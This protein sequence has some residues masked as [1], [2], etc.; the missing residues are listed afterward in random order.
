MLVWKWIRQRI[1]AVYTA[2]EQ[3]KVL[4]KGDVLDA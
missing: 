3:V 4:A 1:V 2:P